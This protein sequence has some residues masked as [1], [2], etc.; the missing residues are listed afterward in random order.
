MRRQT[1][2]LVTPA[3]I[4]ALTL[5][6][7][8]VLPVTG[9]DTS[10][11]ID[12]LR[13]LHGRLEGEKPALQNK[14]N[15][16]IHQIEAGAF[17]GALNKLENDV[18][19]S[20][21]A[22]VE[23]PGEL[24]ELIDLIIDLING[25]M[26][27]P[28][29]APDFE[30]STPIYRLDVVQGISNTT[31][32]TV[33]S[34]NNFN[35][36]VILTATTTA[37]DTTLSFDPG[38]LTPP[39][40]RSRTSTLKVEA[41]T[42]TL[43]SEYEINVTG[44]SSS[45]EHSIIIPLKIIEAPSPPPPP[46]DFTITAS[47]STLTIQQGQSNTSIISVASVNGFDKQVNLTVTSA[48][49]TGVSVALNP[50]KVI[51]PPNA[52]AISAL[53]V[54]VSAD[55]KLGTYNITVTG[56]S[57]SRQRSANIT[58][59]ITKPPVPPKPDFSLNALPTSLTIE[60]GDTGKSI[61]IANSLR[62]FSGSITLTVI[63]AP[64][65]GVTLSLDPT[66]ITLAPNDFATSTLEIDVAKDTTPNEYE[67][68]ITGTNGTLLRSVTVS[69]EIVLEKKPP[70]ILSVSRLP[71][72]TPTYNETVTVLANVVDLESG[73]K[74]V[75]LRY[76]AGATQQD[77]PMTLDTG[78]Y[79]ATIPVFRYN[80]AVQ[81]RVIA[82]DNV[83]NTAVSST[84]SYTVVDPY[85]PLMSIPTWSPKEPRTEEDI[86]VNVTVTEPEDASGI[87]EVI[88]HYSNDTA[89]TSIPMI[90]NHDGNWTAVISNQTGPKVSF[91]VKAVDHAGNT[92]ES[93]VQDINVIAPA[94][95]L[96]WI[97]AAIVI[98]AAATGGGAYYVNRKRKKGATAT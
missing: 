89:T 14:V 28:P 52:Y 97:L 62:N 93:Q 50:D 35:Q 75:T 79:K 71:E 6:F 90:D 40:N 18:R 9:Q 25:I 45:R 83:G 58:L 49:I 7:V 43:P 47:P 70:R 94:S 46:K 26:P 42:S 80:E 78:L 53:T 22:W 11:I 8:A 41:A 37:P 66:Q 96:V 76:S 98:L 48:S 92:V 63:S 59:T 86:K 82:S 55:A 85:P 81:Y 51:P 67:I 57:S 39:K 61:I 56:I 19:K 13:E 84:H 65:A 91:T 16:V 54:E 24:I 2:Y 27:P 69:L 5:S 31:T 30:I 38:T 17:N 73:I 87:K 4:L 77:T 44:K 95:P 10:L 60:Q 33:T 88:L 32:I 23:D 1:L 36:E 20:V 74:D 21:K 29:P 15:A 72:D 64:I 3:L 34:T 68:T 12:K